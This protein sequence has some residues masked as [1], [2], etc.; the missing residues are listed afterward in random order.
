M[1]FHTFCEY[2]AQIEATS[3]RLSMT[4]ILAKLFSAFEPAEVR[5]GCYLLSGRLTPKFEGLEFNFA[6]K[7]MLRAVETIAPQQHVLATFKEMGD[8]G[9]AVASVLP[10]KIDT[11]SLLEIYRS[12]TAM[13][14]EQGEGSQ[15]RKLD[16]MATLL[17]EASPVT[18][19]YLVRIV[20][21]TLRLGFSDM[22]ML[23]ALSWAKV[24][25]KSL[26]KS[27]E[28]AFQIRAD[29]GSLAELFLT[30]GE[31]ALDS[32]EIELGVPISPALCQRLNNADEMIEKMGKVYVEPKYD[33][34]RVLIH[35]RKKGDSW[36][37]RTFTRNL[38]ES[39]G[40]FPELLTA[41]PDIDAQEVVLDSEAV[42][43]D[44]KTGALRKFQETIQRKRKHGIAEYAESVP[45]RFFVF[46][47]LFKDG[48]SLLQQPLHERKAEL[49]RTV[50]EDKVFAISPY[51]VTE[52]AG[53]LRSYHIEQLGHGLEGVVIK[54][55]A[56]PYQPGRRGWSWVKFKEEEGATGKLSDTLD[57]VVM[58]YYVGQ[59]KRSGFG[60]GA[61]LVGVRRSNGDGYLTIAKIGTG[62][63]DVQWQELF[64]RCQPLRVQ[65]K[66]DEYTVHDQLVPDAWVKPLLV[67]EIAADELTDS[68]V[69][70]AGKALRFP[71][72]VRFR[73]DKSPE[74]A[75]ELSELA[76]IV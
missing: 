12:L 56:S 64:E 2:L 10:A 58:G 75:T 71:R 31:S 17:R 29:I 3:S 50:K 73:D 42:G 32:I 68:P 19:K 28:L 45:L 44:P 62:L 63:T 46:D 67:A 16:A 72:L 66:P 49:E 51:I 70:T 61:F 69:H 13:A 20:L 57:C 22:T 43:Y 1:K 27:L 7:L 30:K 41:L 53:E 5:P 6:E 55:F 23:D 39:S 65:A 8:L 36:K 37:V 47:I 52:D 35:L 18:A 74:Q 24:G 4:D 25:D 34:T 76:G 15:E 48:K 9:D 11:R 40:M 21:G 26:R 54:Q 38:E 33:G 59:G 60:L 14:K